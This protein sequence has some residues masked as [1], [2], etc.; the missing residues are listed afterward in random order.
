M[1]DIWNDEI[2][3]R[4]L[5]DAYEEVRGRRIGGGWFRFDKPKTMKYIKV[6]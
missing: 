4:R 6:S 2:L 3:F 5:R 1:T